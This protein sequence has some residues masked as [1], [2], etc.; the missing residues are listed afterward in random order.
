MNL[1]HEVPQR[2]VERKTIVIRKSKKC[3]FKKIINLF[4]PLAIGLHYANSSSAQNFIDQFYEN[5]DYQIEREHFDNILWYT[6]CASVQVIELKGDD[7]TTRQVEEDV[8]LYLKAARGYFNYFYP[9]LEKHSF[10]LVFSLNELMS[11]FY[12]LSEQ[13]HADLRKYC[14]SEIKLQILQ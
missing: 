12:Y 5:I 3:C 1:Q 7:F 2:K 13:G 9:N 14:E 11:A 8:A 6:S 4:I 10:E